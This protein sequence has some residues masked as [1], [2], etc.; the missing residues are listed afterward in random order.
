MSDVY[1]Q[2][3]DNYGKISV[4]YVDDEEDLLDI[5][6]IFLERS[7]D[8]SVEIMASAIE[9]LQS[10]NLLSF[11]AII[12]DYMMPEMDGIEFLKA[13]RALSHDIPF[14]LFTGRGREE[15]VIEA[16]NNGAD[17]YLQKGGNPKAQFAELMH[18]IRQVVRR[19]RV[20]KELNFQ[21]VFNDAIF[22]S[23]PGL[24]YLYDVSGHLVQW[25]KNHETYTGFSPEELS[26]KYILDWFKEPK[27]R[28]RI[29]NAVNATFQDG[30]GYAEATLSGKDGRKITF[31]FTAVKVEIGNNK[32]FT[33]IGIDITRLKEAE[34]E[35]RRSQERFDAVTMNAG[36]WIW[37]IDREGIFQ[38]SNHAVT[39]ILGYRP[40]ELI[41]K[42]HF[43]DLYVQSVQEELKAYTLNGFDLH[44]PFK[45]FENLN[46][47]KN[48]SP[49]L[50]NSCGTPI[51]DQNGEFQGYWGVDEDITERKKI[52][53]LL[54]QAN[55]KL[56]MLA[57]VTRHDILNKISVIKGYLA[58]VQMEYDDPPL[59]EY[60]R[61]MKSATENI[62]SQ[63]EFT[64]T[65]QNL[66]TQDPVWIDIRSIIPESHIP[67][68]ILLTLDLIDVEV[69][70]DPMI[71]KVLLN[72]LDNSTRHGEH[73]TELHLT[74]KLNGDGLLVTWEDNGTGI[75]DDEKEMIFERGYGKNTGLGMFLARE[76]ISLNGGIITETGE[77]GKGARFELF[78]P[79]GTFRLL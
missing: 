42:M 12:A 23:V 30:Y 31:Y 34:I 64:R 16:I 44:E 24:L 6:K 56:S 63:I 76:I 3:G 73:V 13:V 38:Y 15:V 28:E 21:R 78:F 70:A 43:Y 65:Y 20:E 19:R 1:T 59:H 18:K 46:L 74:A 8:F 50:L 72:L 26:G 52:Q 57:T 68:N 45:N 58:V 29:E 14:I 67:D 37:E 27:E 77:F 22:N 48:G 62:Q 11:D 61:M 5:S 75:S 79:K 51:F 66:G 54:R 71:E 53:E 2:N 47:H 36:S 33:G 49:V 41:G 69:F 7:G 35:L 55:Q 39:D 17:F 25:N 32:Y 40:D 60:V 9:A 4:L 10:D